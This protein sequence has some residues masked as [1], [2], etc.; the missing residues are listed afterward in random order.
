M[1]VEKVS[2]TLGTVLQMFI[3]Y[4]KSEYAIYIPMNMAT[5]CIV[6]I[7]PLCKIRSGRTKGR[8]LSVSLRHAFVVNKRYRVCAMTKFIG[9][10]MRT[11][12]CCFSTLS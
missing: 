3:F 8:S 10:P 6:C 4:H 1:M 12:S 2:K 5:F 9:I 7:E 11:L